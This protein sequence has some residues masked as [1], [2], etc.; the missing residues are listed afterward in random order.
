MAYEPDPLLPNDQ[1]SPIALKALTLYG[2]ARGEPT[3]GKRAVLWTIRNRQARAKAYMDKHG[4]AHPL[5][6]DGSAAG[7][8]LK[9]YQYSCWLKGDP[10]LREIMDIIHSGGESIGAFWPVLCALVDKVESETPDQDPTFGATHYVINSMWA[11][12]GDKW[13]QQ[14]EIAAGHT[15]QTIMIGNHTFARVA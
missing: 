5:Y 11:E 3:T 2:E 12:P 10:N 4:H 15:K 13:F 9:P 8:V 1:Q 6:G 14:D 7:V